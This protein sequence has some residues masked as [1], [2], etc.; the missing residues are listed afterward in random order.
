MLSTADEKK[1]DALKLPRSVL[2]IVKEIWENTPESKE[3][4][5]EKFFTLLYFFTVISLVVGFHFEQL[6]MFANVAIV[7]LWILI[8]VMIIVGLL[9]IVTVCNQDDAVKYR[10][11]IFGKSCMSMWAK[12]NMLKRIYGSALF[13]TV[14]VYSAALGHMFTAFCLFIAVL[15]TSLVKL[16]VRK[17]V[18]DQID[19][20]FND[21]LR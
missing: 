9:F 4:M 16:T 17:R 2:P 13:I 19:E 11:I 5:S 10:Q 7:I 8:S 20:I 6:V 1:L 18:Q 3:L 15:I 12:T 14:F 21:N